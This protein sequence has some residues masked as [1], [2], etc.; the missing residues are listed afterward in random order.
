MNLNNI[1]NGTWNIIS[2]YLNY[3]FNKLSVA[4]SKLQGVSLVTFKGV[5]TSE[6]ELKNLQELSNPGDYAFVITENNTSFKVYYADLNSGWTTDDGTYGK[7]G[8]SINY[9]KEDFEKQ[10]FDGI[11]ACGPLPM[12]RSVKEFAESKNVYCQVSLEEIMGCGVGACL[13][14][15]VKYKSETEDTY[16]RVCKE[17]PVFNAHNVEF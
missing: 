7:K 2:N 4:T 10:N 13:G 1:S 17:G 5:Y 8:F 15:A 16:K 14:C 6:T 3:N 11:F 9:L 12:L